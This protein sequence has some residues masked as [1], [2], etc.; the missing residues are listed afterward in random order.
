[1]VA[2]SDMSVDAP[3]SAAREGVRHRLP[4]RVLALLGAIAPFNVDLPDGGWTAIFLRPLIIVTLAV[5]VLVWLTQRRSADG[6]QGP[7]M[8]RLEVLVLFWLA[9]VWV[10]AFA[11]GGVAL[12]TAGAIRMTAFG[13]LVLAVAAAI[14]ER[15][16]AWFVITG[17]A[18]GALVAVAYGFI[19]LWADGYGWWS[20]YLFGRTTGLGPHQRFT[21]PWSHANVTG[22][23]LGASLAPVV[24][25]L[26]LRVRNRARENV[27]ARSTV[28]RAAPLCLLGIY[29]AA[30]VLTYSRGAMI[31]SALAL[32]ALLLFLRPRPVV[33]IATAVLVGVLVGVLSPG[34]TARLEQPGLTAWYGVELDVPRFV[35]LAGAEASTVSVTVSNTSRVVWDAEGADAVVV[36][37]RW[38]GRDQNLIWHEQLWSL[39]DDLGPGDTVTLE[40]EVEPALP[41]GS[42]DVVWDLLLSDRAFFQQFMGRRTTSSGA[43][44][45]STVAATEIDPVEIV[46]RELG[47]DRRE[48]WNLALDAFEDRPILGVGPSQLSRHFGNE[49]LADQRFVPG[50]HAHSVPLEALATW[51]LVGALPLFLLVAMTLVRAVTA[52]ATRRPLEVTVLASLVA[53]TAHGLVDWPLIH[54]STSIVAAIVVGI[55]WC[56]MVLAN[57]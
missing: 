30:L 19:I 55:A 45:N 29:V 41:D 1:M 50:H 36:S 17:I 8:H 44:L 23:A 3:P 4:V 24:A 31:A 57:H 32:A 54:A 9:A 26:F 6:T 56:P 46:P 40:L 28:A 52:A 37:A 49:L 33:P 10:S 14:R 25:L 20:E 51:G 12:G 47:L 11:S 16:E 7:Q 5:A 42:Y 21:R 39:P 35:D 48:I 53:L 18:V 34:W 22:M 43:V 15:R 38:L 27:Q 13:L 2:L